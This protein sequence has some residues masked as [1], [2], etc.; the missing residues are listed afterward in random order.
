MTGG[1][2]R[3]ERDGDVAV[4]VIDNPPV[5]ASTADVRRGLLEALRATATDGDVA[6]V[7]LIGAGCRVG[8]PCR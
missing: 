7:V 2:V 6:G 4:I 8:I 3:T 5:N 1:L